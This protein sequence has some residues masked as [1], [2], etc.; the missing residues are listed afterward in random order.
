MSLSS[1]VEQLKKKHQNLSE[2]VEMM[3]RSPASDDIEVAKLK[4]QKLILK[5]ERTRLSSH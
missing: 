2:N 4:K 1:H 3:Q 5:E